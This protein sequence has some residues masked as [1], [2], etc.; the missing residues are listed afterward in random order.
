M[1]GGADTGRT[2]KETVSSLRRGKHSTKRHAEVNASAA[3]GA[4]MDIRRR[5]V[6][7]AVVLF[8]ILPGAAAM[9]DGDDEGTIQ[10]NTEVAQG[11]LENVNEQLTEASSAQSAN[12]IQ[13]RIDSGKDDV[14]LMSPEG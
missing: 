11:R 12:D 4:S 9:A 7:A 2:P 10:G 8:F 1:A 5:I 3:G 13:G 14:V 6:A